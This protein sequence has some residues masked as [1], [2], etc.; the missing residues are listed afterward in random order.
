[1]AFLHPARI[2]QGSAG[3]VARKDVWAAA[4]G[5]RLREPNAEGV[6]PR[7]SVRTVRKEIGKGSFGDIA[8]ELAEWKAKVGYRPGIEEADLPEALQRQLAVFGTALLEHVRVEQTRHRLAEAESAEA[9]RTGYAETLDEA[10]TQVD[11]LEARVAML[12]AELAR[13]REGAPVPVMPL[14]LP[15][16][17]PTAKPAPI[18]LSPVYGKA[19]DREVARVADPILAEIR[20]SVMQVLKGGEP[21]WV[22]AVH[23][24][25]PDRLKQRAERAG[26]PLTPAWLRMHLIGMA[27]AGDSVAEVDGRFVLA[28][29]PGTGTAREPAAVTSAASV[30]SPA[31]EGPRASRRHFWILFM[32]GVHDLLLEAGPLKPA[33]IL[34]KLP[35]RLVAQTALR[36]NEGTLEKPIRPGR[37]AQKLRG[38]IDHGCPF[39][40]RDGGRFA[41]TGPWSGSRVSD[42]DE[43]P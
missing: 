14:P 24:S 8:R 31:P 35:P 20:S 41:A 28:E 17:E 38:R 27:D 32:A 9:R 11:L 25:L 40:E 19:R 22:H 16:A 5:I 42:G 13:V 2:G 10:L 4:D 3:M 1:M 21:L 26:L 36:R 12:E 29:S 43:T 37:L 30:P 7:V 6:R 34:R 18:H 23:A 15:E 39:A 33:D